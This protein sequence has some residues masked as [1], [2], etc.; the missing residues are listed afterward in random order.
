[1]YS[2][3]Y[4]ELNNIC[5]L[6][7]N[8]LF[9]LNFVNSCML[10]DYHQFVYQARVP[11]PGRQDQLNWVYGVE[12]IED[13]LK[14]YVGNRWHTWAWCDAERAQRIGVAFKRSQDCC[15]FLLVWDR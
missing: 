14:N 6:N 9:F 10:I 5:T 8:Q 3:L 4:Q 13:W 1:M 7:P 11:W 15:L 2:Y 12:T